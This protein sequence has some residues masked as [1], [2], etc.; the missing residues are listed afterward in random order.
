MYQLGKIQCDT[1]EFKELLVELEVAFLEGCFEP[2]ERGA[3]HCSTDDAR[4]EAADILAAYLYKH[5]NNTPEIKRASNP[6]LL[7]LT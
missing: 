1:E 6:R 7:L 4:K 3:G 5:R 2:S